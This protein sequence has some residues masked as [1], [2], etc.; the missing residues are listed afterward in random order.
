MTGRTVRFIALFGSRTNSASAFFCGALPPVCG[1]PPIKHGRIV[2]P[3]RSPSTLG[4]RSFQIVMN[5]VYR[6]PP[7]ISEVTFGRPSDVPNKARL[8]CSEGLEILLAF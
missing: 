2:G 6:S 3:G 8:A 1:A 5:R 4:K 7:W